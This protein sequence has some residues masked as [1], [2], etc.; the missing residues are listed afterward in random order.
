MEELKQEVV[1]LKW[2]KTE[3]VEL[4]E[5]GRVEFREMEKMKD[6]IIVKLSR[7]INHLH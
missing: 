6:E 3:L 5:R 2:E 4:V 7:S 1:D